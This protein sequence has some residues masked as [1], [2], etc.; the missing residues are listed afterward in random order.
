MAAFLGAGQAPKLSEE[1]VAM[2]RG[3]Y[4]AIAYQGAAAKFMDAGAE[5]GLAREPNG[6]KTST[7]PCVSVDPNRERGC[8]FPSGEVPKRRP[9]AD[10]EAA[11]RKIG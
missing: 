9:L 2:A 8:P 6:V 1:H 11:F 4:R 7:S 10:V 3:A 5:R